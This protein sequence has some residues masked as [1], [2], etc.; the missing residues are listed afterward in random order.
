MEKLNEGRKNCAQWKDGLLRRKGREAAGCRKEMPFKSGSQLLYNLPD[1]DKGVNLGMA[2][3]GVGERLRII[4]F[5][6]R[7]KCA[8]FK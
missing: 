7:I 5:G 1:A 8:D 2:Q 4:R 3:I 6:R